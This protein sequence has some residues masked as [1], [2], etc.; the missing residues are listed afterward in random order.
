MS[1]VKP[2]WE[3]CIPKDANEGE[4]ARDRLLYVVKSSNQMKAFPR[5]IKTEEGQVIRGKV[6]EWTENSMFKINLVLMLN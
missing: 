3:K 2:S 4:I 6:E 1:D 5:S